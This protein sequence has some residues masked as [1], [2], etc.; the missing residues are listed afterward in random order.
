MSLDESFANKL[1]VF[2][3][4]MIC[5]LGMRR[6]NEPTRRM[7]V[8]I[9]HTASGMTPT[10]DVAYQHVKELA[11]IMRNKRSVLRGVETS[12]K[13]PDDPDAFHRLYP[14]AYTSESPPVACRVSVSVINERCKSN[15]TPARH[16]SS[17][18]HQPPI[19]PSQQSH[20]AMVPYQQQP[21]ANQ[22]VDPTALM[23]AFMSFMRGQTQDAH[24][25]L[26]YSRSSS[27][28]AAAGDRSGPVVT[29][30]EPSPSASPRSDAGDWPGPCFT[31]PEPRAA[32]PSPVTPMLA[33]RSDGEP[34][35]DER[36]FT[37]NFS[38][39]RATIWASI[40][41]A[42]NAPLRKRPAMSV[43][44]ASA[45]PAVAAPLCDADGELGLDDSHDPPDDEQDDTGDS[46]DESA[47]QGTDA[48]PVRDWGK[49]KDVIQRFHELKSEWSRKR[50][51]E[52]PCAR[53]RITGKQPV[54]PGVKSLR[55]HAAAIKMAH[56]R[57]DYPPPMTSIMKRPAA[58][59]APAPA[60]KAPKASG[61][62]FNR[63]GRLSMNKDPELV[64]ALRNAKPLMVRPP[65]SKQPTAHAGGK[66]Y[67]HAA[68][69]MWRIYTRKGDRHEQR[70]RTDW[71]NL[72]DV[73]RAWKLVCAVIERDPR[74]VR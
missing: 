28:E 7:V 37:G 74:P 35:S 8:A 16:S 18:L 41:K 13:F 53:F 70:V 14:H 5:S 52:A 22:R 57:A 33:T 4:F 20:S 62:V 21:P 9:A 61:D 65:P 72:A 56:A 31:S 54:R 30:P 25:P 51:Q 66:I 36:S 68:E 2:A 26:T 42:E 44:L 32:P 17:S 40:A 19:T 27:R 59:I 6:P 29:S 47:A 11:E 64:T 48:A 46:A 55:R 58:S 38:D 1:R 50:N 24:I 67:W 43:A 3:H 49:S 69:N 60:A 73:H 23:D 12:Q 71:N 39:V 34:G 63:I 15:V 45:V 10:P